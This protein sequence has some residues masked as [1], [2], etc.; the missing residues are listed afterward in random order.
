MRRHLA[1]ALVP[2][3]AL[4]VASDVTHGS[5]STRSASAT[6]VVELSVA[7]L[8]SMSTLVVAGT[9]LESR[10]LWE[11][12]SG[13]RGRRI[14]TYTR[15]RV[16]K[17]IDGEPKG[18]VWVR[19]LGGQVDDI[20]QHVD[21]EAVLSPKRPAML[22]LRGLLDGTHG[23]VGMAQGQYPLDVGSAGAPTRLMTPPGMGRL[24]ARGALPPVDQRGVPARLALSGQTLDE[25][26]RLVQA[27]RRAHAR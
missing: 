10:S 15:V 23:V 1:L 27:E 14:V 4:A 11:D 24:V 16:D 7:D 20:G 3:L 9:P 5:L 13:G 17:V 8:V 6:T 22:F 21:G 25:A 19:T 2:W 12:S 26:S 18:D